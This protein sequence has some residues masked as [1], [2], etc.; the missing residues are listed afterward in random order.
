M[1]V[2]CCVNV[3]VSSSFTPHQILSYIHSTLENKVMNDVSVQIV[4]PELDL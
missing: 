1:C 4:K 3:P 2:E